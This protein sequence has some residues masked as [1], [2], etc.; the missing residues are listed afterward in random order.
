LFGEL[1]RELFGECWDVARG[2]AGGTEGRGGL[3]DDMSE[4]LLNLELLVGA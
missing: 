2:K 4:I 1:L 3:I